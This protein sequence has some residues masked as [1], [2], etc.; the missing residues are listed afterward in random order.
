MPVQFIPNLKVAG[1]FLRRLKVQQV[2]AHSRNL[3]SRLQV[4]AEILVMHGASFSSLRLLRYSIE[5]G[6][7]D[8]DTAFVDMLGHARYSPQRRKDGDIITVG[9]NGMVSPAEDQ[10]VTDQLKELHSR[11]DADKKQKNGNTHNED[12]SADIIGHEDSSESRAEDSSP[13]KRV[14]DRDIDENTDDDDSSSDPARL[15]SCIKL[16]LYLL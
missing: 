15:K 3:A 11:I 14:N 4:I 16:L 8:M 9:C 13:N 1:I 5:K 6:A 10:I 12:I 7:R 2:G